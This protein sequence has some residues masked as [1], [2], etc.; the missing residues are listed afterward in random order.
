LSFAGFIM[1][2]VTSLGD[3]MAL[4]M[5]EAFSMAGKT[6][7]VTGAG[8]NVGSGIAE[9]F[10]TNKA[11][12]VLSDLPSD[13]LST[14]A[15]E[16]RSRDFSVAEM[17][18]DLMKPEELKALVDFCVQRFGRL[19]AIINCGGV[20]FSHRIADE[21]VPDFDRIYH[22]DVRS[23]W[24]LTKY[25]IPVMAAQ[26]G[27][28]IV[29]IASVNGHR[30]LFFCSLYA[31]AKAAVLRM[32]QELAVELA[33]DGIRVNSVSPGLIP[34]PNRRQDRVVNH[35]HEPWASEIKNEIETMFP[36]DKQSRFQPLPHIGH[37]HD[38][39]M[40]CYYLCT[41]AARFVTGIDICVDG[42]KLLE[43]HEAE[44]RFTQ[45]RSGRWRLLREKLLSLPEEA[46]KDFPH[47]LKPFREAQKA[48]EAK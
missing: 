2:I 42:G 31:G 46:W 21:D 45:N 33:P 23:I 43:M 1:N 35:L 28:S 38:I 26:G 22:A 36:P 11:N 40:A 32:T 13:G 6:V 44:P 15:K 5:G 7:L 39:G 25:A 19:D 29:N 9:V 24:L 37:G 3:P 34:N 12:V 20:P 30:A 4:P 47:W 10:A 48:A 8:G 18:A 27:G 41:P 16:L 17:P 14:M